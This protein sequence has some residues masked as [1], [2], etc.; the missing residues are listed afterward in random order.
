MPQGEVVGQHHTNPLTRA[1][2]GQ[3]APPAAPELPRLEAPRAAGSSPQDPLPRDHWASCRTERIPQTSRSRAQPGMLIASRTSCQQQHFAQHH[4]EHGA[5]LCS[6]AIRIPI[7]P[8]R[9]ANRRLASAHFRGRRGIR[10]LQTIDNK[11]NGGE[12]GIRTP[13]TLSGTPVF[14]TGAINHSATSPAVAV[15]KT[16]FGRLVSLQH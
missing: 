15:Y 8:V 11:S 2:M 1:I 5:A 3:C 10:R 14:K 13:G 12:G 7:S 6:G 16:R 4:P 9:R